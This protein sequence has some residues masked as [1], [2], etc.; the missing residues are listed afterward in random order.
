[1]SSRL[2]FINNTPLL[3]TWSEESAGHGARR[4][5]SRSR[6]RG[7][8]WGTP[9]TGKQGCGKRQTLNLFF[10]FFLLPPTCSLSSHVTSPQDVK[11]PPATRLYPSSPPPLVYRYLF[12]WRL[13]FYCHPSSYLSPLLPR[14][15]MS[16]HFLLASSSSYR[17]C[18]RSKRK[19]GGR[20]GDVDERKQGNGPTVEWKQI[21]RRIWIRK[22]RGKNAAKMWEGAPHIL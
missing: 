7:M 11:T 9:T 16:H 2:S 20:E 3:L 15:F 22:R 12:P 19:G 17:R 21:K 10:F 18:K 8:N 14:F 5:E 13:P 4:R 1:M 6:R